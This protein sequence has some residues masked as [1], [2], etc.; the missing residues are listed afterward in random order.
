[1]F[2]VNII[3]KLEDSDGNE[4]TNMGADWTTKWY[5]FEEFLHLAAQIYWSN[6]AITGTLELQISCG[7]TRSDDR[8]ET[9]QPETLQS[10]DVDGSFSL[11]T[12]LES[13]L[14][15]SSFR[16]NFSHTGGAGTVKARITPKK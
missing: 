5:R 1:M 15:A 13:N 12:F 3:K 11:A 9:P 8:D 16:F 10:V 7:T 14:A 6:A 4:I 2:D